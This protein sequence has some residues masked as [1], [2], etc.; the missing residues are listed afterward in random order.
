MGNGGLSELKSQGRKIVSYENSASDGRKMG[1]QDNVSKKG[2]DMKKKKKK[3]L[4]SGVMTK[5]RKGVKK[6]DIE[7]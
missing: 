7:S 6:G 3:K 1:I 4:K 5:A 2:S